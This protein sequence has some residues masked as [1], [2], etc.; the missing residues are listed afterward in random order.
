MVVIVLGDL[1]ELRDVHQ[2]REIIEV[3][4]RIVLAVFA[5]ESDI[6]AEIHILQMIG[7]ETAVTTLYAFAKFLQNFQISRYFHSFEMR[8]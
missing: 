6:L 4:H 2:F 1:L 3:E 5:E 7:D 8:F